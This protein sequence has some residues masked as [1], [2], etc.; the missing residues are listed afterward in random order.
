MPFVALLVILGATAGP[1]QRPAAQAP[2]QGECPPGTTEV[3]PGR[4]QAP[5]FPPPSILDY[6]PR[7]TLVTPEHAVPR[8]KFPVVDI[9]SH[10]GP[11]PATIEQ[12]IAEM[13][14]LHLRVLVNLS[15]GSDPAAVKEKVDYIRS[16]PH[17]DRFRVFAN[18]DWQGAGQ[19][20][21]AERAVAGLEQ[22]VRNGAIG[23][24]VFKNLG[25]SVRMADGTRLQVDDRALAPVWEACG[26]LNIP[27][28]IHTAEPQEFFSP[29]DYHNERWLELALFP[30]RRHGMPGQPTFD[31]LAGERDRMFAAN[32]G[33]RFINAHF[34]WYGNDLARAARLLDSAPNVVMDLSAVLYEFGRQPRAAREFFVK[35]Q[36]RVLFGKDSYV[37]SEFPYYWRVFETADEYFDY[38]RDYHAF[39]KLYGMDLPDEVLRKVYHRNALRVTPGLPQAGWE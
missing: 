35:Y 32:P 18:V 36:D 7:S 5:E 12:L 6:R 3:R 13:D 16:S 26:R 11:T 4:C 1:A 37:P 34:G 39:W 24:K 30:N 25:L 31:Q 22:S 29:L 2:V 8:A 20:G 15:G 10:T 9:H 23:L 33:T 21:W 14:A 38:Y 27:V 17:P 28:L 19:P